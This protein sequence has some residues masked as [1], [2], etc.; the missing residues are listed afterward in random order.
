MA[1]FSRRI[2]IQDGYLGGNEIGQQVKMPAIKH[3]NLSSILGLTWWRETTPTGRLLTCT[4]ELPTPKIN[5]MLFNNKNQFY[6]MTDGPRKHE[7]M[8]TKSPQ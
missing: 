8:H 2:R 5:N 6:S 4:A 7:F 1:A 3:R